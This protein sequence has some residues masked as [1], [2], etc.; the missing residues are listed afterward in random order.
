MVKLNKKRLLV[1]IILLVSFLFLVFTV[2][3]MIG[4][5]V[6][7]EACSL[8]VGCPHEQ[9]LGLLVS[10][11]PL[12]LSLAVL[13]GAGT[14]YDMS[15]KVESSQNNARKTGE[16][17]LKFLD[18]REKKVV[19]LLIKNQGKTLQSEVSRSEGMGK[20]KSH[21]VIQKLS[22]KGVIEIQKN[23]NTNILRFKPEIKDSMLG[24]GQ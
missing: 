19:D 6:H 17:V 11:L 1:G 21:R 18:S 8:K 13:V 15:G 22:D 12:L 7:D 23:G 3:S 10:G 2:S 20:L 4:V 14:Y 24:T 16:I 9:Q 5:G